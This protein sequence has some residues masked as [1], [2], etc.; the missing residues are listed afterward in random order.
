MSKLFATLIAVLVLGAI[1]TE[2]FACTQVVPGF[3]A[4]PGVNYSVVVGYIDNQVA[5][6]ING[7]VLPPVPGNGPANVNQSLSEFLNSGTN[8]LVIVGINAAYQGGHD[9]NPA[10]VQYVI[11]RNTAP[12]SDVVNVTCTGP[13]NRT[14]SAQQFFEHTYSITLP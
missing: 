4:E 8:S 13:D 3:R 1:S 12:T 11:R 9:P 6:S 5:I 10:L 2:A 14:G 7:V